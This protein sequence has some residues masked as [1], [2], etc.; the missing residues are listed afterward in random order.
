MSKTQVGGDHY[1]K[2]PISPF[3]Y[4]MANGLDPMQ[5]TIIKYVTRFRD[6]NGLQDLEKARDT[7]NQL[8]QYE[9]DHTFRSDIDEFIE[10]FFGDLIPCDEPIEEEEAFLKGNWYGEAMS[11]LITRIKADDYSKHIERIIAVPRGGLTPA[12][13]I[14]EALDIKTVELYDS[15]TIYEGNCLLVEDIVD[16]GVSIMDIIAGKTR[17]VGGL[18]TA[19]IVQRSSS[20]YNAD[21]VGHYE[22]RDGYVIFPWEDASKLKGESNGDS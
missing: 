21:F 18:R 4:G 11:T 10:K 8:I 22:N 9:L 19:T 14:A 16:S 5:H 13:E 15:N 12:H 1:K 3:D 6:K 17:W 7:I 2:L 20:L